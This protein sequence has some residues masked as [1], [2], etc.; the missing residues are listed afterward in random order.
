MNKRIAIPCIP[1]LCFGLLS[2]FL[3]EGNNRME[4]AGTVVDIT[5]DFHHRMKSGVLNLQKE[6]VIISVVR[7]DA[8][9]SHDTPNAYLKMSWE[10]GSFWVKTNDNSLVVT[11][12][13]SDVIYGHV[14]VTSSTDGIGTARN[15]P[16]HPQHPVKIDRY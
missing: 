8:H 15:F 6:P 11:H 13:N 1:F 4:T 5:E 12:W 10:L 16:Q 3:S 14:A 9:G 7:R 2:C